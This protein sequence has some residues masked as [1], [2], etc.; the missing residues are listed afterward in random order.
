MAPLRVLLVD[1]SLA[2]RH[3]IARQLAAADG[4]EVCGQVASGR[5]ALYEYASL[6][7]D[8]V[9]LD[10]VMPEMDGEQVLHALLQMDPEAKVII[11]SSLATGDAVE[12]C[13]QA[14]AQSFLQKP[15]A[16]PDLLRV[17]GTVMGPAVP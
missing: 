6:R 12:R 5:E 1:D 7:P 17:L 15:F 13:L 9:L 8:V 16:A 11:V 4:V 10:L 3:I 14:G 2:Q